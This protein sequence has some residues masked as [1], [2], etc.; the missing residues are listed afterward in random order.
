MQR[1]ALRAA[2]DA[3][4]WAAKRRTE[5]R[6]IPVAGALA[7]LLLTGCI[8]IAGNQLR[9]LAPSA[10]TLTP[11]VEQTVGG[12]SFHLDGGKMVTSNKMGRELNDEIL[13]RWK[14][15]G[16]I[17][18]H[19]Y[20]KSSQFSDASKYRI[21]LSGH[22]EGDS[23]IFLQIISGLTLT[24]I[25]YYVDSQMDLRYSLENADS[26]CVF[27][28]SVSDSYNTVVGL[29]LL[30]ISPFAQGGRSHTFDRISNNLYGQLASQG[31]FEQHASCKDVASPESTTGERLRRLEKLRSEGLISESEYDRKREEILGE[32]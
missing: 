17:S 11:E 23:S 27:E 5:M 6:L 32:L 9:D 26:G 16:F 13:G 14:K 15:S 2:A 4:R 21:T 18:D 29:L 28:A 8:T 10:G 20:V 30:P 3:E 19:K 7:N 25:P 22:Q 31:A 12:F 24:A 1:T